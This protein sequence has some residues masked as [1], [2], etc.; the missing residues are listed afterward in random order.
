MV[1][2]SIFKAGSNVWYKLIKHYYSLISKHEKSIS[3]VTRIIY[4]MQL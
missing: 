1:L 4:S 2:Y 3:L